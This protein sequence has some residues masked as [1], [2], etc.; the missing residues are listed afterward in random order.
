MRRRG[1]NQSACTQKS[2]GAYEAPAMRVQRM[3]PCDRRV[4]GRPDRLNRS[5]AA[6]GCG[7]A[8]LP[9]KAAREVGDNAQ[10]FGDWGCDIAAGKCEL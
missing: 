10:L 4:S 9:P 5:V 6:S 8:Q 2:A 3:K 7:G 1:G